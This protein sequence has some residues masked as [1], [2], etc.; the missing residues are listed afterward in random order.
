ML[1]NGCVIPIIRSSISITVVVIVFMVFQ[2]IVYNVVD[3]KIL[4]VVI[5]CCVNFKSALV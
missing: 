3:L 5:C 1:I 4:V 2:L